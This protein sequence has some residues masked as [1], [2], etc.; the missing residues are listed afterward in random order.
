[1]TQ[2]LNS[3]SVVIPLHKSNAAS[4]KTDDKGQNVFRNIPKAFLTL[5][6]SLNHL[7]MWC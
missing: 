4:S 6:S 2:R 1:M 7:R 3:N 5:L